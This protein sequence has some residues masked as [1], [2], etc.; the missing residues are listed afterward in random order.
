[1]KGDFSRFTFNPLNNYIAVLKQQ[2]RAD[3]DSDWNEQAAIWSEQHR[4]LTV[5]ILGE[6][7]IP[8]SSNDINSDNSRAFLISDFSSAPGGVLDF[9]IGRGMAFVGG[10]LVL[11]PGDTTYRNQPDYPEP[12]NLP[13]AENL[14]VFIEA[15][16]RTI[17]FIDNEQIREPALGGPDTGLRQKIVGQIKAVAVDQIH[18]VDDGIVALREKFGPSS[19]T[20]TL[21]ID[22]SAHQIPMSFGEIDSGGAIPGNLHYRIEIHRGVAG[23]GGLEEGVKWSDENGG[24][25]VPVMKAIDSRN[26]LTAELEEIA[27]E[28]LKPGDWVELCNIITELHRQGSQMA[29]ITAIESVSGGLSVTLD[30]D[31]YPLLARKKNGA[32]SGFEYGL[33]PRLRRWSGFFALIAAKHVYDLGRGIKAVFNSTERKLEFD[34]GDYWVYAI[35]DRDY[36]KLH[37]PRMAQPNGIRKFRFPLA[38]IMRDKK[39]KAEQIID[40]RRF[41]KPLAG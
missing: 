27:G 30:R 13:E 19:L 16:E 2:G 25:V 38:I 39:G 22:Q 10:H 9:K 15:W 5:T 34:P 35:R 28:S 3:L 24:M 36:N 41:F 21:Q 33:G 37:A 18:S 7:A 11:L 8:L 23:N 26:I 6:F 29:Q 4:L 1:M 12:G 14:L 17:S 40:L 32:G 31:I 20:L